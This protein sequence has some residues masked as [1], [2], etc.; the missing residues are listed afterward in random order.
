MGV[1]ERLQSRVEV[2][3]PLVHRTPVV[4]NQTLECFPVDLRSHEQDSVSL[5]HIMRQLYRSGQLLLSHLD[6]VPVYHQIFTTFSFRSSPLM[7]SA[8]PSSKMSL[9]SVMPPPV[10]PNSGTLS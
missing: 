9:S 6:V 5:D 10:D 3:Q 1:H 7:T 2:G 8:C 4:L